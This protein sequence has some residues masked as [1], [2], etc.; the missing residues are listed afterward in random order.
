MPVDA[1]N[2]HVLNLLSFVTKAVVLDGKLYSIY[3]NVPLLCFRKA[4][5]VIFTYSGI[6]F[7]HIQQSFILS[8][9]LKIWS[10]DSSRK[11][12]VKKNDVLKSLEERYVVWQLNLFCS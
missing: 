4:K 12:S 6:A 5:E 9:K 3:L 7:A 8:L 2:I 10:E 11:S 1:S